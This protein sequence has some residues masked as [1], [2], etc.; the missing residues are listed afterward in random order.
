[1][2]AEALA[3]GACVIAADA[4]QNRDVLGDAGRIVEPTR[5]A[6]ARALRSIPAQPDAVLAERAR[7]AAARFSIDR[8]TERMIDLYTSLLEPEPLGRRRRS[9]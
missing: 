6:F 2:Q 1:M 4:P 7:T 3:A 8:Q 5:Q 9:A